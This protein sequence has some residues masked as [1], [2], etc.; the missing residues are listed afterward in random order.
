MVFIK[1]H[2]LSG[3]RKGKKNVKTQQWETFSKYM[4]EGG[5]SRF[6]TEL[7]KLQGKPFVDSMISLLEF[8][9]PR[10]ARTELTDKDGAPL[11]PTPTE[12]QKSRLKELL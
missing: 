10:L 3:S 6:Q 5:L 11:F 1:G 2:K 8:F 12:N 9:K 7:D 4:M